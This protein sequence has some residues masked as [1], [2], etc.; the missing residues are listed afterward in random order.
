ML[1]D[2]TGYSVST[3]CLA[4][5]RSAD[6][7]FVRSLGKFYSRSARSSACS[8]LFAVISSSI[9]RRR[10]EPREIVDHLA[11]AGDGDARRCGGANQSG[12]FSSPNYSA[13]RSGNL[14]HDAR[15][16][17]FTLTRDAQ[18]ARCACRD[19]FSVF[20]RARYQ[21]LSDFSV[22]RRK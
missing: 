5:K 1:N 7:Q 16:S 12:A 8:S 9:F 10:I 11:I 17:L 15:A 14:V 22:G 2:F 4:M 3:P 6:G 20:P 13:M 19:N 21:T 18:G